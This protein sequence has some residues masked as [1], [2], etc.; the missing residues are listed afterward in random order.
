M[1]TFLVSLSILAKLFKSYFDRI[2]RANTING[3]ELGKEVV[4]TLNSLN[5]DS[6]TPLSSHLYSFKSFSVINPSFLLLNSAILF[7][8]SP[9]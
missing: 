4:I 1:Y 6:N 9:L 7:A 2:F 8:I 3:P 5:V